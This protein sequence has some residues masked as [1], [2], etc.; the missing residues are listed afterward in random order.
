MRTVTGDEKVAFNKALE[1]STL[2]FKSMRF[3]D[4][5]TTTSSAAAG[6]AGCSQRSTLAERSDEVHLFLTLQY[7]E[8][9]DI[10]ELKGG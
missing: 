2:I 3:S 7:C 6:V 9:S 5:C 1:S 8:K 10:T 4:S